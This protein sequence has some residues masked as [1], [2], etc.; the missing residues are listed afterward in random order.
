MNYNMTV[1]ESE[2]SRGRDPADTQR[3]D[4]SC[5][6]LAEAGIG[7]RRVMCSSPADV[8]SA[9]E[10]LSAV[11]ERGM[12][13]LPICEYQGVDVT[14]G[15]YPSD[16]DLADFLDVPDGVLSVNRTRPPRMSND[17]P[18]TC[19]IRPRDRDYSF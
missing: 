13:A 1:Y 7:L 8:D 16:Q 4:A 2:E 5:R 12:A 3:F 17:A 9:G 18:P 14:D 10:A 11:R 19:F 15:R 6:R